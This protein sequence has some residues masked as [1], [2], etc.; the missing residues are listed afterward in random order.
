MSLL[1]ISEIFPP[2]T[3]GSGRWFFEIYRRLPREWVQIAAGEDLRQE[4]F[5][6]THDL[7]LVRMPLTLPSW[8][9]TNW[10]GI[11]GYGRVMARLRRL[12]KAGRVRQVHGGRCLP[13][14]LM[15]LVLKLWTR[16]PYLCYAHGEELNYA[17][18]CREY[19][20]LMR[21]VF[22]HADL[23]IA[24]SR[25]TERILRE[26]WNL[27]EQQLRVLHPGVDTTQFT[28][29]APDSL[30]RRAMGWEGRRVVLTVGRLEKRKGHDVMIKALTSLRRIVPKVLYAI[31]GNGE[32]RESLERLVNE[33]GVRDQVQFLGELNDQ[34]LIRCYQQC[35]LFVLPNRQVGRDIEGFGMV[36][37]EAQACGKPV[38]AGASGG[39]AE[40]ME[41]SETGRVVCCDGP[42]TISE[43]LAQLLSDQGLLDEMGKAGRRM[44][45][46]RFDWENL[47]QQAARTF[48]SVLNRSHNVMR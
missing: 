39:T 40:T 4:E 43:L 35:D 27:P 47:A 29:A 7:P 34:Q 37:V 6:Q 28:P 21:R 42:E 33:L 46:E 5:D 22:R 38:V 10:A 9:I 2:K 41:V 23:V 24:N 30:F 8:G 45:M 16:T 26:E 12:V 13:E 25:N 14:G 11:R 48:G 17:H 19:R 36:L 32:E 1:L 18:N 31:I 44:V 20:W 15:A 3:G